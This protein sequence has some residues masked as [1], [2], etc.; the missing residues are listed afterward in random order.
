MHGLLFG[1]VGRLQLSFHMHGPLLAAL[2]VAVGACGCMWLLE[3]WVGI[4]RN[5]ENNA[6]SSWYNWFME[7]A[8]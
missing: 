2:E 3:V 7:P 8:T 5:L 4:W 1:N 6:L